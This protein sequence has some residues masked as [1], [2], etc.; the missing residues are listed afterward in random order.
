[1]CNGAALE[2]D[3]EVEPSRQFDGVGGSGLNK[4]ALNGIR[5]DWRLL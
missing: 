4:G 2:L 3:R 5:W 1:M